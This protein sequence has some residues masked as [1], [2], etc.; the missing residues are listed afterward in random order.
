[1]EFPV[2]LGKIFKLATGLSLPV[3]CFSKEWTQEAISYIVSQS[4]STIIQEF[5]Q[6]NK[7]EYYR[8]CPI[9]LTK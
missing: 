6:L 1:V 3:S 4:N 9:I 5:N 2:W 8:A 7:G